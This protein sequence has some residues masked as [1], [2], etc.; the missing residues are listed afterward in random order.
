VS[1]AAIDAGR[2]LAGLDEKWRLIGKNEG[3]VLRACSMTLGVLASSARDAQDLG[4]TIAELM[5][6][7]PNRTVLLRVF[8]GS[9][10]VEARTSIQCWMPFGRRQQICCEQ[11][12]ISSGIAS[13]DGVPPILLGLTVSDLPVALWCP[14]LALALRP[15]LRPVVAL[16]GKVIVD[17]TCFPE[18]RQA[19]EAIRALSGGRYRLADLVW[20]RVTRWRELLFQALA[21][22]NS[23]RVPQRVRISWAGR[24]MPP[25][26]MY[27]AAWLVARLGWEDNFDARLQLE[28]EDPDLPEP[29]TGRLR[30][31]TVEGDGC[32]IRL[33]RPEGTGMA[34]E[35][36]GVSAGVRFPVFTNSALLREELTV[37]GPDP[38]FDRAVAL[39]PAVL[40]AAP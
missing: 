30:S 21:S 25:A 15:E 17:T 9:E 10:P 24:P 27:L 13:L 26:A 4:A 11:I 1:A 6:E 20:T 16:A 12:E 14:D 31:L 18:A 29:G 28:C 19:L 8:D 2:L 7:H 39:C 22:Q 40:E 3:G 5:H 34:I 38:H 36:E 23:R 35:V 37:F 33:R 32:A